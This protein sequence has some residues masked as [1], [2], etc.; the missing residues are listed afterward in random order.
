MNL[1]LSSLRLYPLPLATSAK[2][3][4]ALVLASAIAFLAT[5][6]LTEIQNAPNLED[7]VPR[8]FADWKEQPNP[9]IQVSLA[10]GLDPNQDLPYDQTVTRTYANSQGDR[11]MLALAWGK[12]QRQEVKVHRPDLCYVAQGFQVESLTPK[13]FSNIQGQ[14][15]VA[16]GKHML[17][18]SDH[19]GEAVSYWIRIGSLYSENAFETRMH[20]FKEGL[21]GRVQDGILVRASSRIQSKDE[22]DKAFPIL[23]QFLSDLVASTPERTRA[24][25]VRN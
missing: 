18:M 11:V 19:G 8:E 24:M 2:L 3:M 23:D 17:V 13:L 7:T 20:I 10:T 9:Y 5:P 16:T 6:K 25:L 15:N 12:H 4:V 22:A 14:G 1:S 21:S